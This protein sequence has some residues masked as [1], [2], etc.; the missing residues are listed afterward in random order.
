MESSLKS[1][2]CPKCDGFEVYYA[3]GGTHKILPHKFGG[4]F[5]ADSRPAPVVDNFV[6]GSC[7]YTEFYVRP[8]Y[9]ETVRKNWSRKETT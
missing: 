7:G 8:N 6:C 4:H 3:E 5:D 9:L 1:G 2:V